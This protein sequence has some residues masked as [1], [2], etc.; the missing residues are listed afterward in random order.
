MV[1]SVSVLTVTVLRGDC[2]IGVRCAPS[3]FRFRDEGTAS[4]ISIE[5]SPDSGDIMSFP[6]A[7]YANFE[8]VERVLRRVAVESEVAFRTLVVS[9][10]ILDVRIATQADAGV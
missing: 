8:R 10:E 5:D 7:L 4:S 2:L 1:S 9:W 3:R 6:E